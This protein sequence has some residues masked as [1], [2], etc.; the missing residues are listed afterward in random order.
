MS[1]VT[2]DLLFEV[3]CE[4]LPASF[5]DAAVAALPGLAEKKLAELRLAFRALEAK[6]TPRRLVLIVHALA[7]AQPDLEE[8]VTGPPTKA[9]FKDGAPT[10]AAEAFAQKL[11]T[12]VSELRRVETPKGEYLVGT[13]REKGQPASVLL[14][15]ALAAIA[16]SIPFRKSMRWGAGDTAFGRPVQWI[17]ALFGDEVADVT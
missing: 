7:A 11:G 13:R 16:A 5:V 10:K 1:P 9:A 15:Q 2:R 12:S 8:E 4:E 17:V 14:P 3:G 6:G